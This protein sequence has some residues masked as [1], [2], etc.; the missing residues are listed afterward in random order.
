MF[1]K[2]LLSRETNGLVSMP[3]A[4]NATDVSQAVSTVRDE[5]PLT[6]VY[7][8]W[9]GLNLAKRICT[10]IRLVDNSAING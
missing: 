3:S 4:A 2:F 6:L 7:E 8:R 1:R 10:S 9:V 5:H